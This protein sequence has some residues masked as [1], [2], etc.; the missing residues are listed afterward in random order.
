MKGGIDMFPALFV[1]HGSPMNII[2]DN[3]Y[4]KDL[5][6]L[7]KDLPVPDAILVVSAHWL[8]RGTYITGSEA[9]EQIYDF[10]GFPKE[11][12]KIKYQAP[13]SREMAEFIRGTVGEEYIKIDENRGIDHAAWAVLKFIYPDEDI[14]VL[15]MSLDL[16]KNT[17]QHYELGKK[18]YSLRKQKILVIG[19]GNIVHNLRAA[20]FKENAKPYEWAIDFD[21]AVKEDINKKNFKSLVSYKEYGDLSR[22]AVPTDEHYLPMIYSLGMVKEDDKIEYVHESIQNGSVSMRCFKIG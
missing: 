16:T 4:T 1:G 6:K 8:T 7:K 12:Y 19:S 11:L 18:L 17:F 20:I 9:P 15:E 3:E 14:P 10:Y 21:N 13:G 22:K 2:S 5:L